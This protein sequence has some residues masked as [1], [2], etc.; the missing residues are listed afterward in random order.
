M[1][2]DFCRLGFFAPL[3][4]CARCYRESFVPREMPP[5]NSFFGISWN[6]MAR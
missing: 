2:P 3:L 6:L 5:I 1:K 4:L